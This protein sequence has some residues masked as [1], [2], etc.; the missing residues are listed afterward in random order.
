MKQHLH[1]E[2]TRKDYAAYDADAVRN[3]VLRP[4]LYFDIFNYPLTIPEI[5]QFAPVALNGLSPVENIL[6][7]LTEAFLVF[8]FG[9]FYSLRNDPLMIERRKNG[10][11]LAA[12]VLQ[13]ALRRSRLI[14][15]FPFVRSVNISG[16][17]S[18][19]YFDETTDFDFF[20]ITKVNRLWLCRMVLTIYKKLF[21]LNSRKYFCINYYVD[22]TDLE[23]PDRNIFTA[24]EIIT[25]K[26]QTGEKYYR[27]F[28]NA[29]NWT[30]E[31]FPNHFQEYSGVEKENNG[32]LKKILEK[33]L[34]A[35]LGDILDDFAFFL[36]VKFLKKRYSH[37]HID[38]LNVSMRT[39]K[40]TS[41]HHPQGF[42]F[43][44]LKAYQEKCRDFE[45]QHDIILY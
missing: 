40:H 7:E 3:A 33:I 20:I 23:I 27:K 15:R 24:M 5:V 14:H 12:K 41:K 28:Q 10:N 17:L 42:Q 31:Y 6:D 25:L 30:K 18:K 29:N 39:K 26:N 22:T 13:K 35:R 32:Y 44:V 11:A 19:N 21:L 34:G 37:M 38:E 1:V 43:K 2:H 36:T 8:K 9:E 45:Q 16:S 4:L